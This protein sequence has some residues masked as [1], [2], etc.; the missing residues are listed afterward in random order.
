M[1]ITLTGATVTVE[2]DCNFLLFFQFCCQRDSVGH[3]I[4]GA[5]VGDHANNMMFIGT[6]MKRTVTALGVPQGGSLP[7]S[8]EAVQRPLP[9]PKY[10]E[11]SVDRENLL[12]GVKG[13]GNC[14]GN[15]LLAK[16]T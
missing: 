8:K 1:K 7:L 10:S 13:L 11:V 2:D 12:I 3:S 6:K 16:T 14:D 9:P 4:L 5:K 15:C